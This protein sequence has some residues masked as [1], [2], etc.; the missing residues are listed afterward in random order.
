MVV[1]R[2]CQ[3]EMSELN[4]QMEEKNVEA[5]ILDKKLATYIHVQAGLFKIEMILISKKQ[6]WRNS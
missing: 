5:I 1:E 2:D 6:F 3:K 4:Q